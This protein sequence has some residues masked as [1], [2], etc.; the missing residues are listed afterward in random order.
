MKKV[1]SRKN[2]FA[3][4]PHLYL[5]RD[6]ALNGLFND[7]VALSEYYDLYYNT[8][9]NSLQLG[10]IQ[11]DRGDAGKGQPKKSPHLKG[12]TNPTGQ[13]SFRLVP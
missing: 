9:A 13:T 11:I 6:T 12:Q 1:I 3:F 10:S 5:Q 8:L 7:A 4:S 2:V